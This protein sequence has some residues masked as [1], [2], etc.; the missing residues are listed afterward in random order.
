MARAKGNGRKAGAKRQYQ[1]YINGEWMDSEGEEV[2]EVRSPVTGEVLSSFPRGTEED[3]AAA[4]DA[5]YEASEEVKATPIRQ[6]WDWS[7]KFCELVN[8][9]VER[10]SMDLTLEHGKTY[11]QALEE[12]NDVEPNIMWTAEAMRHQESQS[13]T[14]F[15]KDGMMYIVQREPLGVV[16]VIMPWNFPW[17]LPAEFVLQAIQ[18]GNAVV[19]K[20]AS[21]TPIS[22]LHLVECAERVGLPKG[23]LNLVTGPG[24]TLGPALVENP[25]V[26]A[27]GFT[28]ETGTGEDIAHRAGLKKLTLELG[29]LG[30]L[31]IM[32]D[33]N[34]DRAVEDIVFGC[35]TNGGQCCVANERILVHEAIHKALVEKLVRK[36][37]ASVKLGDPFDESIYLGPLNNEPTVAKVEKH[38]LD[39]LDRGAK[40][41]AGGKRAKGFPT[42]LY[43]PATV[44]DE[45]PHEALFNREETF[46]PTAPII[47]FSD[48]DEAMELANGPRY[49]LSMGIHTNNLRTALEAGKRLKSGQIT[50]NES[51]Y[52]WD[53]NNPWGGFR[54]TGLGRIAARYSIEA[55]QEP[56]TIV[57]NVG[58]SD[59]AGKA[60]R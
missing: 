58:R 20:P 47:E 33:A 51:A 6:R 10:Y 46:G 52:Y 53:Y 41:L 35:Y 3:M 16:G 23:F 15:A 45:V 43:Y 59:W 40:V 32:D 2:F 60:G 8:E 5:A 54:K 4:V 14:P 17:I 30:P 44:I 39:A 36:V 56:K 55:F 57:I 34:L 48:F 28:G 25:K 27:I 21:T 19:F 22:A 29:G 13:P 1:M 31:I 49:G 12:V 9:N 50:I 37:K 26:D 42:D 7:V 24:S 38:V 18:A 11:K